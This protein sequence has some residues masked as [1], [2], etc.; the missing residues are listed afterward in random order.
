MQKVSCFTLNQMVNQET[1]EQAINQHD[2]K[3][4]PLQEQSLYSAMLCTNVG[5][6]TWQ[7]PTEAN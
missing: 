7:G 2:W 3:M 1:D 4:H 6:L 5:L